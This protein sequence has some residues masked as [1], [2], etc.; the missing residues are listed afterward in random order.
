MAFAV[1]AVIQMEVGPSRSAVLVACSRELVMLAL[2]SLPT[3][4][5][6]VN[7]NCVGGGADSSGLVPLSAEAVQAVAVSWQ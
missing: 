4:I 2:L 3:E 5:A 7:S 6:W 1:T